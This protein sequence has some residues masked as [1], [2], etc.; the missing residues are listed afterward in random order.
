[1]RIV[2]KFFKTV[3]I[4]LLAIILLLLLTIAGMFINHRAKASKNKEF[5]KKTGG[6]E[7]VSVGDHSLNLL[8]YGGAEKKHRIVALGGNGAGFPV[9]LRGLAGGL[10][11]EGAVYYLARAGYDGSDDVKQDMTVEFVVEDYRKALQNAGI[12]AP[13]ILMPHSYAGVLASYWVNKYPDEIEAMIALDGMIAQSF[14][15]EQLEEAEQQ[16]AGINVLKTLMRLGIGDAAPRVFFADNP[17]YSEEEQ[18]MSDI[19]SLMTMQSDA[20]VSDIKCAVANTDKTWKMMQPNDVPKLYINSTNAYQTV[21]E[22]MADDVLTEYMINELTESFEG[23][24]DER[25][26][27]AYEL[28]FEER[29]KY[30][31]EKILPYIEKLG[32]CEIADLPGGHFIHLEKP[33]KCA[34]IIKDFIGGLDK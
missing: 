5:L 25:K 23:S 29:E 26:A 24:D 21:D 33:A 32:N 13:Y 20:F 4:I 30:K 31:K 28:E 27:K 34:H 19:M 11:A 17:D 6:C 3:G 18:R 7:L 1:M 16:A 15:D 10:T 8:K 14:T 22:L 12:E 2:K 9:E